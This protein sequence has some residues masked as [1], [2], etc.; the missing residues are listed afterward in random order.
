[1]FTAIC[2]RDQQYS[3]PPDC[4]TGSV[5]PCDLSGRFSKTLAANL[6]VGFIATSPELA[7]RLADRKMLSTLT[8]TEISERVVYKILSEGHYR[9]HVDRIRVRLD[10]VRDGICKRIESLGM[11]VDYRTGRYVFMDRNRHR[12]Q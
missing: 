2:I 9:K 4:H 10:S 8:T 3:Q 12:Y 6:R 1:M 7:I 11:K 5:K